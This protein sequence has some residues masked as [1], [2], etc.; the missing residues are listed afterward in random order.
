MTDQSD[1]LKP[2]VLIV[3]NDDDSREMLKTSLELWDYRTAESEDGEESIEAA[4]SK[5][6]NLILMDTSLSK[7]D[8]LTLRAGCV[9]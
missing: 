1:N 3:E 5:C 9:K 4:I 8:G 6:P 7:I 2:L